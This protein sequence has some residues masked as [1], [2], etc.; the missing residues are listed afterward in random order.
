MGLQI[1]HYS[2]GAGAA[3]GFE[4]ENLLMK[5]VGYGGGGV[6]GDYGTT[7]ASFRWEERE[8][9][10]IGHGLVAMESFVDGFFEIQRRERYGQQIDDAGG[11]IFRLLQA[12]PGLPKTDHDAAEVGGL[13]ILRESNYVVGIARG[14]IA[15][16]P[17]AEVEQNYFRIE[18]FERRHQFAGRRDRGFGDDQVGSIRQPV[19]R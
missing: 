14:T 8:D 3:I 10:G 17:I 7:S 13:D 5:L 12:V 18:A 2:Q 15:V 16:V 6:E 1:E 9:V 4:Q 11:F 19:D